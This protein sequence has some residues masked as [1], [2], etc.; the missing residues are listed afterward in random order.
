MDFLKYVNIKQG[1]KSIERFSNGNTLPLVQRPF[2]F[3]SFAPQTDSSR[4][5]WFYHPED[6][7]FEGIRFTHQPSPWICDHGALCMLPQSEIP[8]GDKSKRWSG[9]V[10]KE[11]VLM[12]HYMKYSLTRARATV[13]LTSTMYGA[14]VRVE[15]SGGEK[16]ISFLPVSGFYGYRFDKEQNCL[17]CRTDN[18]EMNGWDSGR[19]VTYYVIKFEKGSVTPEKC[20]AECDGVKTEACEVEGENAAIHLS[21]KEDTVNFRVAESFISEEQALINLENDYREGGFDEVKNEGERIWNEHLSRIEISASDDRMKTFYSCMYR[22]FLFP[23]RAYETDKCGRAVHYAPSANEVKEGVRYTDNGFWD[24]YRTVYPLLAIIA[25]KKCREIIEGFICDYKD[26]G[27]LPCWTAGDAKRCMPSTMIDVVI[28][29]GAA[30]GIISGE[31]LKVAFEG[32]EKH[33]NM[34]QTNPAYGREGCE[35]Y[36]KRGY[37]PCDM[38]KESVNLTLD[39]AYG[40]YCLAVV[41]DILCETEKAEM[42]RKRSK[43]Y[44]NIFD[45]ETG[46]MRGRY[47]D[48]SFRE[49]FDP[50]LWGRDYTEAAAWQTS[51]GVPHDYDGLAELYGGEEDFLKKLDELFASDTDFRVGGYEQEIHEMTEFAAGDWGQCAISN[52]PSFHIPFIYCHFKKCD[53]TEYWVKR[54]CDE[55]FSYA[56]DGFPGDEDN[57][58][59]AA[60][61]VFALLGLYPLCP[62]NRNYIRFNGYAKNIKILGRDIK[63]S[64]DTNL[65]DFSELCDGQ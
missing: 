26:G 28:A 49:N 63:I 47:A 44:K 62:G 12:P 39:A 61:Y 30:K 37:V 3:A 31:L 41:A 22:V 59:M 45:P 24:T 19:L 53:K 50:T 55:A 17:L 5:S 35:E 60:W 16:Y 48:G 10:E 7:S 15:F 25:P 6:R 42:Y 46:F 14:Y 54:I 1:T 65:V 34:P 32:M 64:S 36:L 33:A 40:D 20:I 56:D 57:G 27:W 23:H 8:Y 38:F 51:F 29:D 52:Q 11:T 4:K 58:S 43:N 9:F 18:N 2:G 13:E 21:I